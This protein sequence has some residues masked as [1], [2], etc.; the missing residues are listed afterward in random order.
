[1]YSC[2]YG[3]AP[4]YLMDFCHPTSNVA[5]RQQLRSA[6]RRLL[7]V[8]RCRLKPPPDGLSLWLIHRCGI[9]CQT[10]CA[11]RVLAETNSDNIW[12]RLCS[13]RTS[14]YSALEVLRLC[15]IQ[16]YVDIDIDIF[17]QNFAILSLSFSPYLVHLIALPRWSWLWRAPRGAVCRH[18]FRSI[19]GQ[20]PYKLLALAV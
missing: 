11:I 12:K 18:L 10:T 3:Q 16:I 20:E 1:M 14:A 9:L 6:S 7:V 17:V 19:Y 15:A 13:L 2:M 4:Q 5:S 8:S